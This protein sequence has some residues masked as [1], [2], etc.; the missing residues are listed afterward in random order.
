MNN[1]S[2][3]QAILKGSYIAD[4][5]CLSYRQRMLNL[6]EECSMT[7]EN[8]WDNKRASAHFTSSAFIIN[9]QGQF[10]AIFHSKLQ[11]WLQPGG[12]IETLDATP[13]ESALR[14]ASEEVGDLSLRALSP[15]PIDLDIHT[16]PAKRELAQ[17]EHF[18]IRY[19]FLAQQPQ[20]VSIN[21]ESQAWRWLTTDALA[22]WSEDPSI[23]R[24]VLQTKTLYKKDMI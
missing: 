7:D 5:L 18:D 14:E 8:S 2:I 19:A 6:V 12:H 1:Q 13:F 23:A 20:Q 16:I 22:Q 3:Q 24:A 10:L 17:H 4:E 21:H 9:Q 11:R 15:F